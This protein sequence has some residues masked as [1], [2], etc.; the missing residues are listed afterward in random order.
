MQ[1]RAHL[2]IESLEDCRVPPAGPFVRPSAPSGVAPDTGDGAR[3]SAVCRASRV[4]GCPE[5]ARGDVPE[6]TITNRTW[7]AMQFTLSNGPHLGTYLLPPAESIC[8]RGLGGAWITFRDGR[9]WSTLLLQPGRLYQFVD[10]GGLFL[11][12]REW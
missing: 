12:E 6:V 4:A 11:L 9:G 8:G 2:Q 3:A 7:F 5:F 10:R 1:D